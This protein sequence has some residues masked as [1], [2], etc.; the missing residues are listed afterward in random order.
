M[1]DAS[2]AQIELSLST[3]AT[4]RVAAITPHVFRV[5]LRP[6]GD[7]AEP[8]LVRYGIVEG[9]PGDVAL[10]V[11]DE[12]GAV[13]L[14]S[15]EASLTVSRADGRLTLRDAAGE[16]VLADAEAPVSDPEQGFR[17]SFAL[18]E[19][20]RLYGL[21]DETR[22]RLNKR[23]HETPMVLRNVVSYVPIPFLM[24][25]GG[26]A[27]LVNSTWFHHVDA[28]ANDPDRLVFSVR[29]GELDL[30]LIAGATLP[31]LLDH[32]TQVSGRPAVLPLW[33]YGLTWV[34]DD[35]GVRARDVLYEAHMFRREGIPLDAIGLEPCWMQ[36]RYDFSVDKQWNEETFHQPFWKPHQEHGGFVGG[37]NN[38]G[39]KLS[40]WL[41]CDYDLSEY[42]ELLLAGDGGADGAEDDGAQASLLAADRYDEDVIRDPHFVPRYQDTITKRG[43]PWFEHLKKFVDNGAAA[44]KM[45]GA[46]QICFHPDR[47]WY[48]GM[49]DAEMHNLYPV[50]LAKQMSRG[51]SDHTGRRSM[52]YT[53]GGYAGIQQFAATWAGDT[54]GAEKPLA[55]SYT[56]LRAHET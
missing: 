27:V 26:W 44:F 2:S 45:D 51:F 24:S 46:N 13:T 4:M 16:V 28:G 14:D 6:D 43:E 35:R 54:G 38:M 49:D 10:S 21:G 39:F 12:D 15:G 25:T 8:G 40:L 48:N 34:C 52:I 5:R 20:E 56:H 30:Y 19:G 42:E 32:Y 37:L 50:L 18:T 9:Q 41:C 7:F 23:G 29:Q 33:A 11:S 47:R 1:S 55:V 22:D 31:E 53:A 3:G 17:A 36:T